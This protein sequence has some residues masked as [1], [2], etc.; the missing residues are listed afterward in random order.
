M[1]KDMDG[2]WI[3]FGANHHITKTKND[4]V[5]FVELKNEEQIL[6][7][8]N[9]TGLD[10]EGIDTYKLDRENNILVL[11]NVLFVPRIKRNLFSVP[12]VTKN[13]LEVWFYDNKILIE[14]DNRV[15]VVGIFEPEHGLFKLPI[16]MKSGIM[17]LKLPTMFFLIIHVHMASKTGTCRH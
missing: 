11:K 10:V 1:T 13:D 3:D 4:L 2:W 9:D 17:M 12:A 7:I 14:K 5:E 16:I 15:V 6:Y 8:R